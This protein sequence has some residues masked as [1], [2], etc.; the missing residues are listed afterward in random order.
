[1]A[2]TSA[3]LE[4]EIVAEPELGENLAEVVDEGV[5]RERTVARLR[6]L[7]EQRRFLFRT[8]VLGLLL[9]TAMAFLIPKR[10][11]STTRLMPPDQQAGA[12]MTMLAA[13]S[14][15]VG[16]LGALG[17]GL[18]GLKTPGE[19][20]VGVLQSRTVQD[21]LI[22]EFNLRKVY[23]DRYW[24]DARKDL[25]EHTDISVDRKSGIITIKVTDKSAKRAAAMAQQHVTELN[26]LINQLSTSAAHRERVFLEER[27]KQVKQ[28]LETAEQDFSQFASKNTAINIPEQGKAM[29]QAAATLQGQLIAAESELEGLRQIYTDNNVRVRSLR[30]RVAELQHQLEKLGGKAGTEGTSGSESLYP[31]I[32]KLP[33]LGVTYADLYRK[34]KIEEAVFETLTQE[35]ELARVEEARE[36]PVVKVLDAANVP[37]KKSFPPRLLIMFLGI[38]LA[39]SA[40]VTCVF[41]G[42]LWKQTDPQDPG[43]V[44]AQE[45]LDTVKA[46]MPWASQNGSYLRPVKKAWRHLNRGEEEPGNSGS[47]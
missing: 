29:V 30:A 25:A 34:T 32:R 27:R 17:G 41:G 1:M 5:A 4:R 12:A 43:K 8:T 44:L 47:K 42:A 14:G 2:E 24:E 31:P 36:T 35:Y 18:L 15:K 23:R 45:V 28:E 11:T 20:F 9:T 46:K 6:L 38:L 33:L 40:G 19:L 3:K 13:M 26:Q 10:Y 22:T 37:D 39:F 16:G 7:W 21:D